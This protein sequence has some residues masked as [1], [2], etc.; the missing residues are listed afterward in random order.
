MKPLS[1]YPELLRLLE[2]YSPI[3]QNYAELI[4]DI[5]KKV[6]PRI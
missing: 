5:E 2:K 6:S 3:G 1:N 4:L